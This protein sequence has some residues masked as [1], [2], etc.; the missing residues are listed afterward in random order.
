MYIELTSDTTINGVPVKAG[1]QYTIGVD[2]TES[3]VQHLLSL[4]FAKQIDA[5]S[6]KS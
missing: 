5:L 1:R 6:K 2:I 3:N 4:D